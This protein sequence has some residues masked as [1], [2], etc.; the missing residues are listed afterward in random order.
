MSEPQFHPTILADDL[1][2]ESSIAVEVGGRALLLCRSRD[3]VYALANRC[4]HAD[5]TLE[6]GLVRRGWVACPMHGAR[7]DLA[8]GKPMNPPA[9]EPIPTY[10]VRIEN[11]WIEIGL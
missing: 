9:T 4:S 2:P 3:Q 10:P 11:G 5:E 8:T 6:C 1:K 7:F